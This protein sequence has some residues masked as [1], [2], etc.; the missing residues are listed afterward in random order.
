MPNHDVHWRVGA[1]SGGSY[2][3]Y[4]GYG[5]PAWHVVAETAG[6]VLGGIAGG[7]LPDRIDTP[8]SPRHRA[9]AH[10]MAVTGVAG[11]FVS[12]QLP[13]WQALLRA[14][15]DRFSAKR[16]QSKSPLEQFVF[17]LL[18]FSWHT[19]KIPT[20]KPALTL[21]RR[22]APRRGGQLDITTV[23]RDA[24]RPRRLWER[25]R[26][27]LVLMEPTKILP[28]TSPSRIRR[29]NQSSPRNNTNFRFALR[30]SEIGEALFSGFPGTKVLVWSLSV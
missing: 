13:E 11:R 23:C 18:E 16:A 4:M 27:G 9:E 2:A 20:Q 24:W 8:D 29:G 7:V 15:A 6:G 21:M 3:L 10:S 25:R 5:Q 12:Q 17:W 30:D 1:I 26:F 14:H 19:T 22:L 28:R